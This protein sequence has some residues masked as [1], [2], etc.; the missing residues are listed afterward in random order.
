MN[1]GEWGVGNKSPSPCTIPKNVHK[2]Q[3]TKKSEKSIKSKKTNITQKSHKKPKKRKS[4]KKLFVH[5][6]AK[7]QSL[8]MLTANAAGMKF[9]VQSLKHILNTLK[10]GI[11]TLQETHFQKPGKIQ[12][13]NWQ[14]FETI[15]KRKFGGTMI[16]V[17]QSL[18]PVLIKQYSDPFE[19]LVT[20]V[21]IGNKDVR[22]ISGYGPQD[23]WKVE[24]RMPFFLALEEEISKAELAGKSVIL[25]FDSN[26]KLGPNW[27]PKDPNNQS[28]NGHVLAGIIERHALF[29]ANG[30]PDKCSGV[31]TRQRTTVDSV[32][33]SAIDFVI[34]SHD[35]HSHYVSLVVD[36]AKDHSLTSSTRTTKG[37]VTK[38]SDHNSLVCNFNFK[39]NPHVKKH[40]TEIFNYN[41]KKG[42]EKFRMLTS[43]NN[44]LTSIL[45]NEKDLNTATKKFVKSLNKI[46]HQSFQKIRIKD[47]PNKA[48][49]RLF[50]KRRHLRTKNDNKSKEDL[51][52]VEEELADKC[53]EANFVKIR[54]EIKDISC[55]EG[56]FNAGKF[57]KLK[58]KL[59]PRAQDPPTAMLDEDGNLVTSAKGV[60]NISIKHYSKVLENRPMADKH[61]ELQN[62][63]ERL[64]EERVKSAKTNKTAPWTKEELNIVLKFLKKKK[65]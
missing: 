49:S 27:I 48:I 8:C 25:S 6:I 42:L 63:K 29:V 51:K 38:E 32:E 22:L 57:W 64:C 15:R 17:H 31:I 30:D 10:I 12:M 24:D 35:M 61:N 18:N 34:M 23:C 37:T 13:E 36:E 47:I 9:R 4:S 53:A 62:A 11:F 50:D 54:E 60:E 43:D 2:L 59:N 19:L 26:S 65:V 52:A 16:G 56:G 20:E 41:D 21:S 46:C 3:N 7:E 1:V 5:N 39:Y 55:D 14:I 45:K 44:K 33:T 28:P 58:K 40:K